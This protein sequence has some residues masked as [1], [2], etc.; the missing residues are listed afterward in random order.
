M[1]AVLG[2][3][4]QQ[5]FDSAGS[6]L[7]EVLGPHMSDPT[8]GAKSTAILE[9]ATLA[10]REQRWADAS[11]LFRD[12]LGSGADPARGWYGLGV[13][14]L[15][16]GDGAGSKSAFGQAL[17]NDPSNPDTYFQL[18]YIAEL[19]DKDT[20]RAVRWYEQTL[21]L[22]PR[23]PSARSRIAALQ[24]QTPSTEKRSEG[25]TVPGLNS[26]TRGNPDRTAAA[27]GSTRGP[28]TEATAPERSSPSSGLDEERRLRPLAADLDSSG[29]IDPLDAGAHGS[30]IDKH[31]RPMLRCYLPWLL[32][33]AL[34]I[35]LVAA[36]GIWGA[37]IPRELWP[38]VGRIESVMASA[39][40][41]FLVFVSGW[42]LLDWGTRSYSVYERRIDV[43]RG[44][45][46]RKQSIVWLH[47]VNHTPTFRQNLWESLLNT[48]TI[49][50]QSD[51]LPA[52][53]SWLRPSI[54][55]SGCVK[56]SGLTSSARMRELSEQLRTR[57][58]FERRAL[59]N[60]FMAR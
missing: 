41:P 22:A 3:N 34:L 30:L 9:A 19:I 55:R 46:V 51:T 43:T 57:I 36:V 40:L 49:I 31:R 37:I 4:G 23:H 39:A 29:R 44:I 50:V 54:P 26:G 13:A 2:S 35:L 47:E 60:Q 52:T 14:Q 58:L 17:V 12:A 32:W 24:N 16:L 11:R 27:H 18:G 38:Y 15:A 7:Q 10:A 1:W 8:S 5:C 48:G 45:L 21:V 20:A 56:V 59:L 42:A 25:D 28:Q 33:P 53:T 6:E